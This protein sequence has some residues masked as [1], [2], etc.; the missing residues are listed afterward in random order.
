MQGW[1]TTSLGQ[2]EFSAFEL[3]AFFTFSRPEHELI[4][5]HRGDSLKL[6][7]ALHR[8]PT[9]QHDHRL[10][11]FVG[12]RQ[13]CATRPPAGPYPPRRQSQGPSS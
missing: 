9:P 7:L 10:G 1:Q 5:A 11:F 3:Q 12:P 8:C 2:R 4:Q 6:G 13:A